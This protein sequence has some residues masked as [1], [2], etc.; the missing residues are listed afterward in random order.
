MQNWVF[1]GNVAS[2]LQNPCGCAASW[3]RKSSR[4]RYPTT[5]LFPFFSYFF[6]FFPCP[7]HSSCLHNFPIQ[8][9]VFL[10][11]KNQKETFFEMHEGHLLSDRTRHFNKCVAFVFLILFASVSIL[12]FKANL[13]DFHVYSLKKEL[14]ISLIYQNAHSF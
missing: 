1:C 2:W 14:R 10:T 13:L 6:L 12:I 11:K 9:V 7:V 3:L 5:S 8:C 4:S